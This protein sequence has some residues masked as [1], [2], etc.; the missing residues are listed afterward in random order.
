MLH[1]L[2]LNYIYTNDALI[3][4]D[5]LIICNNHYHTNHMMINNL[6][7]FPYKCIL[8]PIQN[9]KDTFSNLSQ[10]NCIHFLI[11]LI[12]ESTNL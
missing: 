3:Y 6:Y 11:T 8:Y 7:F 12:L 9:N 4:A 10:L 2:S 1:T 5:T